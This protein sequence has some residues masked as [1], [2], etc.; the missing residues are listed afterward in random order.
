MPESYNPIV[1]TFCQL[2]AGLLR[3]TDLD[4][5]EIRPG[6]PLEEI[7]PVATRREIWQDLRRQGLRL[8]GLELSAI[9][10][11]RSLLDVLRTAVSV[12]VSMQRAF[13]LFLVLALGLAAYRVSRSRAV[14]FPF[15]LK[16]VGELVIYLISFPEHKESGYLWTRNEIALK[17]R[18]IVAESMGLPLEVVRPECSFLELEA[19]R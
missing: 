12:A 6:T 14:H 9:D 13:D 19:M 16:T 10:R 7:L 3:S 1:R 8:P 5:H 2:R 17:V 18:L 15:G 4:R 11:R